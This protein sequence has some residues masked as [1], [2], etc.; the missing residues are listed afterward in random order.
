[1]EKRK[2]ESTEQSPLKWPDGWE[3]TRIKDRKSQSSWK[4]TRLQYTD[5]LVKEL[6]RLGAT[7]VLVTFNKV[8]LQDPGVAVYFSRTPSGQFDWQDALE[9]DNPAPTINEID[10]AFKKKALP[11]HPDRDGGD[12]EIFKVLTQHRKAAIAWAKGEHNKEHEFVIACDK[13]SEIRM[14]LAAIRMAVTAL[15]Q[16]ERVGVS[17]ILERTFRGF[18]M[19]LPMKGTEDSNAS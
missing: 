9:I 3:R 1:M 8:D 17:S 15:R 14:N 11:Y 12:G 13:Y 19:A 7:D 18:R 5:T 16:L 6:Q 2:L 10:E 4:K